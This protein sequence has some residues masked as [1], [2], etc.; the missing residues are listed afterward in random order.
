[1]KSQS[2]QTIVPGPERTAIVALIPNLTARVPRAPA[3]KNS[4][5]PGP[6]V[7]KRLPLPLAATPHR[8]F[9]SLQ[10]DEYHDTVIFTGRSGLSAAGRPDPTNLNYEMASRVASN[11]Q[12]P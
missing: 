8:F 7:A 4:R 2:N 10:V 9:K 12:A 1:L 6:A 5:G 3:S 11:E